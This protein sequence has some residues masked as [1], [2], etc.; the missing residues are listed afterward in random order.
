[1]FHKVL[2]ILRITLRASLFSLQNARFKNKVSI[3][4]SDFC[5]DG[6]AD[7]GAVGDD[8]DGVE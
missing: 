7:A 8:D 6:A 3:F 5:D 1:M 2:E 4:F